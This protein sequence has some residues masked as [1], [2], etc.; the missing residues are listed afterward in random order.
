MKKLFFIP[1]LL[2]ALTCTTAC[3]TDDDPIPE[4]EQP[5]TPEEPEDENESENPDTPNNPEEPGNPDTPTEGSKILVAYFSAQGHTQAVAERIVELTG[6]D[7]YRIEA[8][9]PYAANPY[10]DSDRIQ[11]EAYKDLRPGVANLPDAETIAQYEMI[12]VGSPCWW[13]Q[14]AMV[15][16]TFLE[17]YDLKDKVIVPFFTYGAT[18]YLNESMQKIYKITPDSKHIPETLP[19][20]LAPNDITVP[21]LPDDAGIDMP[22]NAGGTEAWLRRIGM[23]E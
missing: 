16:C 9:E 13:H 14:P 22:G 23:I 19:E 21:G 2:F 20:D 7:V 4:T 8:A 12:F 15:V 11:N 3:S 18:T 1:L 5:T 17:A 6:A 10:D